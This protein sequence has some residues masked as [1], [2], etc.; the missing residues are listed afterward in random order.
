[1]RRCFF[2]LLVALALT[3]PAHAAKRGDGYVTQGE[4]AGLPAVSLKV[5]KG[6]CVGLAATKLGFPRGVL[7]LA[8]GRVLVADLGR[9]DANA[10]R[11]LMLT[12]AP[13]AST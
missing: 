6:F 8:D 11:L 1:M 2:A 4:C 5:A 9:W 3:S 12:P 7:P 13:A 10:G